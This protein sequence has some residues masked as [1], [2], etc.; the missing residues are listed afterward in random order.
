MIKYVHDKDS[1]SR[2]AIEEAGWDIEEMID[3]N[4]CVN[5]FRR[6]FNRIKVKSPT[7]LHGLKTLLERFFH[8]LLRIDLIIEEKQSLRLNTVEH[9]S[10]N[11]EK[12]MNPNLTS[13]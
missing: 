3:I 11:H 9:F 12:C 2:K 8:A 5:S 10:G 13:K 7:K 6:Q 1:K 4:H